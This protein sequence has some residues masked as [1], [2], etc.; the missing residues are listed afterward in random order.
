[1]FKSQQRKIIR[2][3]K[4]TF[5]S[6]SDSVCNN[7]CTNSLCY[8]VNRYYMHYQKHVSSDLIYKHNIKNIFTIPTI[9]KIVL[10]TTHKTIVNHRKNII[11]FLASLQII[12]GQK[13]KV[14]NAKKNISFFKIRKNQTIGCKIDLRNNKMFEFLERLTYIILPM[15]RNFLGINNTCL[16]TQTHFAFSIGLNGILTF[17]ELQNYF[18]YFHDVNGFNITIVTKNSLVIPQS[19]K[20]RKPKLNID[21]PDLSAK[22]LNN[23]KMLNFLSAFQIPT[24]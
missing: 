13:L 8:N 23:F 21:T 3:S 17:P 19:T 2:N 1:M 7:V 24:T 10:N 9:Q 18:E 6:D 14:T 11:P 4:T 15:T 5:S 16:N 22:K 20:K 12:S